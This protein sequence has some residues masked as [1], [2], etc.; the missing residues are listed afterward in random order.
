MGDRS[1]V[2]RDIRGKR[3]ALPR[4]ALIAG[5]AREQHG[6]VS[7]GQLV[8][9][10]LSPDAVDRRLVTGRLHSI[11]RA[12]Y[13]VGHELVSQ[14]GRWLAAVLACGEGA[15][16]SHHAAAALWGIR[17]STPRIDVTV[18]RRC[19]S[20]RGVR[21]RE[22]ALQGD[23]VTLLDAIPVTTPSRTLLDL[24]AVVNGGQLR[25]AVNEAEV[26]RLDVALTPL[27]SRYPH[28]PGAKAIRAI[29]EDVTGGEALT[30]SE[31]E[32]R[33]VA[34]VAEYGLPKPR[35][36][37]RV[38]G[39]E[40]DCSW[41]AQR[42]IVELDG[43]AFHRTSAAFE[44]DRARDRVLQLAGWRVIRV[45]WRQLHA[46]AAVLARDLRKLLAG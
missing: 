18:V 45:T 9:A 31:L 2:D 12:V 6:V 10:G 1:H 7:R 5:L 29:V 44:T 19:R 3:A 16:L 38:E 4:D 28:A 42:L 30:R 8:A 40:V 21:I 22:S 24:A 14:R 37:V 43:H 33:F 20:K 27:L 32:D 26:L 39:F 15:A 11:H 36:N 13:A 35:L 46:T 34:F 41:P 17:A 25:K 23:E